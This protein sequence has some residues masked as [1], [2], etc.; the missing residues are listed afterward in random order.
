MVEDSAVW[1]SPISASTPP[2]LDG[3]GEIGV[4]ENVAG[5]VD[6]GA[7]AVPH[8]EN[9]V[10]LAFAAQF[11]LLRAPQRGRGEIL[12]DAGLEADVALVEKWLGAQEVAVEAAER[13]AAIAGDEA[14]GIEPVAAVE[15]LL[16]QAEP[17]QRLEAGHEDAALAEIVLVVEFDVAQ[18]HSAASQGAVCPRGADIASA[19]AGAVADGISRTSPI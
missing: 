2:C 16:H 1:S 8:A 9:A 3:A 19:I 5:A 4:A 6:A 18:R 7:L 11:G 13:R 14:G 12:V 15:L 10:E 17:H